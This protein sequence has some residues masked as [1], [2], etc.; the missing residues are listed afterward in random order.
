MINGAN[1]NQKSKDDKTPLSI[2]LEN[3]NKKI[4]EILKNHGYG[5]DTNNS[6]INPKKRGKIR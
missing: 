6:N 5:D 3:R 2:A 4:I 1:V